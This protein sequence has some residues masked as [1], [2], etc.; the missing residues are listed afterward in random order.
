M[1]RFT[2]ERSVM[3]KEVASIIKVRITKLQMAQTVAAF[4]L[5]VF[6]CEM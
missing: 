1:W 5:P 4:P 6:Y 3:R 2:Q